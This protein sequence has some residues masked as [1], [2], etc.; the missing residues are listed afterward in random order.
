M[1]CNNQH[2]DPSASI[3]SL[4]EILPVIYG[5]VFE[6]YRMREKTIEKHITW[7]NCVEREENEFQPDK[8]VVKKKRPKGFIYWIVD[9]AK[10]TEIDGDLLDDKL[11]ENAVL[12]KYPKLLIKALADDLDN[13]F[14]EDYKKEVSKYKAI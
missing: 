4:S 2:V 9:G 1:Q 10:L 7:A 6:A 11:K 13:E 14:V 8:Y 12:I 5:N 3:N